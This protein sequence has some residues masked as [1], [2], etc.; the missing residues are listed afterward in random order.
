MILDSVK[1][2]NAVVKEQD[3][4]LSRRE[5]E[6]LIAVGHSVIILNGTVL[7]LDPWINFHPGGKKVIQHVVG[8]DATDEVDRMHSLETRLG[9]SRFQI[10]RIEGGWKNFMPPVQ[11]GEFRLLPSEG[12]GME[13]KGMEDV[14]AKESCTETSSLVSSQM[15]DFSVPTQDLKCR[16]SLSRENTRLANQSQDCSS[17]LLTEAQRE[18]NEDRPGYLS[19]SPTAQRFITEKYRLLERTIQAQ[20]LYECNYKAYAWEASRCILLFCCMV[21]FWYQAWYLVSGCLLGIFWSQLV[22][23]AHDAGHVAITHNY[24]IDTLIAMTIAAPLGGLSMGWWKYSHNVHHIVTNAPEHDPDNQHLPFLAVN[25]RF[26][27]SLFSTFHERFMEYD[28]TARLLV[29]WQKYMY[30]P[31][32]TL[33]RFN[34]Y[35]QSWLFLLFGKGPRKGIAWWHRYFEIIGN[36]IFWL[37]YGYGLVYHIPTH[38]SRFIFVMSSHMITVLL[39]V[40]FTISHFSMSTADLG[41]DESFPQKM[42]RTT[43]DVECPPWLDWFHGGLQFQVVHH[44]FPRV[45]RHNL[46]K[47]QGLVRK[48]CKETDIEYT[49]FGFVE[50]NREVLGRLAE[51]SRQARLLAE[52]QR[53]VAERG[54]YLR[55]L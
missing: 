33:G 9:M 39:H 49:I 17:Y 55:D 6:S 27:S 40:Q 47:V 2:R 52:C 21:L 38:Q 7:K 13:E 25:Q 1:S 8:K 54:D 41:P 35:L 18:L 16:S 28:R 42:L 32:L 50:G 45:P 37:W 10:G 5:I 46:R 12:K 44:L 22:F 48:F 43:M 20:G 11:G 53:T 4:V 14:E 3:D 24:T 29:P 30:Y 19:F 51:V 15:F 36:I 34:L 31:I 26:L 23:S